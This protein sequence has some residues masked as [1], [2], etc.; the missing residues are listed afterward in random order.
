MSHSSAQNWGR[1]LPS[2]QFLFLPALW[3]ALTAP[4][5]S[6]EGWALAA[7]YAVPALSVLGEGARTAGP[8]ARC[9][10][11]GPGATLLQPLGLA[12]TYTPA[13]SR[14][15][16]CGHITFFFFNRNTLFCLNKPKHS[17]LYEANSQAYILYFSK[18][19]NGCRASPAG[20]L[21]C[22]VSCREWVMGVP[23]SVLDATQL[24]PATAEESWLPP[25]TFQILFS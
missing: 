18:A 22:P 9:P 23:L 3:Q 20:G 21:Q 11:R 1:T 25:V 10:R 17:K 8:A 15:P 7:A 12:P 13:Q 6:A 16:C 14:G 19:P 24:P 5:Q 4:T 2:L